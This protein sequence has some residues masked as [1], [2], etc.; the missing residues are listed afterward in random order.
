MAARPAFN[1]AFAIYQKAHRALE[2]YVEA[3]R[4]AWRRSLPTPTLADLVSGTKRRPSSPRRRPPPSGRRRPGPP[5]NACL[6]TKDDDEPSLQ[7]ALHDSYLN[8]TGQVP[9][10]GTEETRPRRFIEY[11]CF[12]RSCGRVHD[13]GSGKRDAAL[14]LRDHSSV[15]V[16]R[17]VTDLLPRLAQYQPGVF[18][19]LFRWGYPTSAGA[20]QV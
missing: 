14:A 3:G 11:R 9:H 18:S 6:P 2:K 7:K 13:P 19:H 17:A 12:V 8:T 10:S 4:K 20:G 16:R 1:S 15:R 5:L